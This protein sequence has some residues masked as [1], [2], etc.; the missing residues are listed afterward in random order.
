MVDSS[1]LHEIDISG[2][3]NALRVLRAMDYLLVIVCSNYL[4]L[5]LTMPLLH[6]GITRDSHFALTLV[7]LVPVLSFIIYTGWRH[8][9]VIDVNVW[10]AYFAAFPLL[11]LFSLFIAWDLLATSARKGE[12]IQREGWLFVFLMWAGAI[13]GFATLRRLKRMRLANFSAPLVDILRDLNAYRGRRGTG[14]GGIKRIDVPRGIALGLL[15]GILLLG[16]ALAPL[17]AGAYL[18]QDAARQVQ[19]VGLV[20]CLLLVSARRY[21]QVSADALLA[22]DH[23]KPILFLRSFADDQQ[24]TG[25]SSGTTGSYPLFTDTA[26]ASAPP[27]DPN[28]E[29]PAHPLAGVAQSTRALGRKAAATLLDFSLETRLANHFMY[30]GPFIAVGSPSE[31]APMIGAARAI[32]PDSEWQ[33]RVMAWMSASSNIVMYLGSS[34]WVTW[35]LAKVVNTGRAA[36]LILMFPEMTEWRSPNRTVSAELEAR[37]TYA[38][39]AFVN[40]KWGRALTACQDPQDVR[41]LLFRSD[42]SVIA[43]KSGPKNRDAY[44]LAALLAH[45]ILLRE[46]VAWLVGIDGAVRDQQFAVDTDTFNIGA[47]SDNNLVIDH[48]KYVSRHHAILSRRNGD[49]AIADRQSKNGT[50]VNGKKLGDAPTTLRV[51]DRIRIGHSSFEIAPGSKESAVR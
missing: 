31:P 38:R 51:G 46:T 8:V 50:F 18:T 24:A 28:R 5:F 19:K 23:R 42:G 4:V 44:H 39:Q 43:I 2:P 30:F 3:A 12:V 32:L 47:A 36:K 1:T 6:P 15:G 37:M 40:T 48:D 45:Y 10:P 9:G 26:A 29:W 17:L 20:G 7:V 35:E 14:A 33:S 49:L 11:F 22:A 25:E 34:Q 21:F 13:G 16:T 41:A 27:S